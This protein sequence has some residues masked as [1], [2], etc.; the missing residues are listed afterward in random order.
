MS[1]KQFLYHKKFLSLCRSET[2]FD[3][4]SGMFTLIMLFWVYFI[5]IILWG[6]MHQIKNHFDFKQTRQS[7]FKTWTP[8]QSRAVGCL[9]LLGIITWGGVHVGILDSSEMSIKCSVS[10][11][12]HF[13]SKGGGCTY[14]LLKI[15][16]YSLTGQSILGNLKVLCKWLVI[17]YG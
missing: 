7:L 15:E 12:L 10:A 8:P 11:E 3:S 2:K 5:Y 1:N 16:Y 14:S 6:V 9:W 17:T 13:K 4:G